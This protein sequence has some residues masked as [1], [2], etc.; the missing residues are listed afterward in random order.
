MIQELL[1]KRYG[2]PQEEMVGVFD[3]LFDDD[4][5]FAIGSMKATALH[6]PGHTPDHLGYR[7]G[8]M[9]CRAPYPL[10]RADRC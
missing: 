4:E 7:I 5:E 8:G 2:L 9:S 1:G 6:L 10:A 3:R